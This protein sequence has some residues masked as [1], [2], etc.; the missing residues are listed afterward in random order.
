MKI[1]PWDYSDNS[2]PA[3]TNKSVVYQIITGNYFS[4]FEHRGQGRAT[5]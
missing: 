4:S 3:A 2:I 1:L 5:D